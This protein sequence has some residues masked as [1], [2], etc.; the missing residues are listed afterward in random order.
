MTGNNAAAIYMMRNWKLAFQLALILLTAVCLQLSPAHSQNGCGE[1][2]D[3]FIAYDYLSDQ[4]TDPFL[5]QGKLLD[6]TH[7][8][9][10]EYRRVVK[11]YPNVRSC[12]VREE[13]NKTD[14]NLLKLDWR[15]VG[16]HRGAQVC[17]FRIA[18]SLGT[19]ERIRNWL[20]YHDFAR[21]RSHPNVSERFRLPH[22]NYPVSR[23]SGWWTVEQYREANPSLLRSTFGIDVILKFSLSIYFNEDGKVVGVGGTADG[24]LN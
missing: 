21:I 23:I 1:K 7:P 8:R 10:K 11:R 17:V 18:N 13:A 6:E 4:N 15:R 2:D 9:W 14:P 19:V 5:I 20:V 24:I 16:A 3:C 12:L 22:P